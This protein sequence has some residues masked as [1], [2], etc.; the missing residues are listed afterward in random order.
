MD[1][2]VVVADAAPAKKLLG[3]YEI[4]STIGQGAMGL[5]YKAY[6]TILERIV[7]IKTIKKDLLEQSGEEEILARFKREAVSSGKLSHPNIIPVYEY[8]EADGAAYIVMEFVEGE[9]LSSII[10]RGSRLA[11]ETIIDIVK[12]ILSALDY[13]HQN[14]IVHRD[15]K[16]ANL[17]LTESGTVKIADFGIAH[18]SSSS[19]TVAGTVMGTPSF[20]SPEQCQGQAIDLRSDLFSCA[21]V[22]YYLLTG[23]KPFPGENSMATMQR[24]I[25][26]EPVPPTQFNSSLPAAFDGLLLKALAKNPNERFQTAD[27]FIAEIDAIGHGG[28]TKKSSGKVEKGSGKKLFGIAAILVLIAVIAAWQIK[29][30]APVDGLQDDNSVSEA[31]KAEYLNIGLKLSTSHGTSPLLSLGE[32]LIVNLSTEIDA[33]LYCFLE[34]TAGNLLK[35]RPNVFSPQSRIPAD[36]QVTVPSATDEFEI[37][38]EVA[39]AKEHIYCVAS[40]EALENSIPVLKENDL[41]PLTTSYEQLKGDFQ[42]YGGEKTEFQSVTFV[43]RGKEQL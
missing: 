38:A 1:A 35:V 13:A 18:V 4:I 37:I 14:G 30:P 24:V 41:K 31:A 20:M 10:E 29:E 8:Q 39:G 5:V 2:T 27:E 25:A 40:V 16:P 17:I 34:D 33:N 23:E 6:D 36:T 3:K 11:Y 32:K 7:A 43:T 22:F 19:L 28:S 42:R 21:G 26:H 9:E 12:Q 15:V